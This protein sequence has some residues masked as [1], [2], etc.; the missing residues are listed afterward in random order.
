MQPYRTLAAVE[1]DCR[2]CGEDVVID[3]GKL[4]CSCESG[5]SPWEQ[6]R[7]LNG[8]GTS[9]FVLFTRGLGSQRPVPCG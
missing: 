1:W 4:R 7:C 9:E 6:K 2:A 3:N 5:P 8:D